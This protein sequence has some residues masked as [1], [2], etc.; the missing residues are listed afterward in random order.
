VV[1]HI[2]NSF[3]VRLLQLL[4]IFHAVL[5]AVFLQTTITLT[6]GSGNSLF[7]MELLAPYRLD[8]IAVIRLM[9]QLVLV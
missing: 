1:T 8:L 3:E 5:L 7:E 2:L 6:P 4:K 9:C